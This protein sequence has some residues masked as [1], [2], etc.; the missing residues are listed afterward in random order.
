MISRGN[1]PSAN[2]ATPNSSAKSTN[3]KGKDH[4]EPVCDLCAG[5]FG[6]SE[7]KLQCEG[8]CG[9]YMHRYSAGLTRNHFRELST[10]SSPFVCLVCTQHLHKAT[11]NGL[12]EVVDKL[13]AE[14]VEVRELLA[15]KSALDTECAC[16]CKEAISNIQG[17]MQQ[18]QSVVD[19]Q[20]SSYAEI[21]K[22]VDNSKQQQQSSRMKHRSGHN[23]KQDSAGLPHP[24]KRSGKIKVEGSRKVWGTMRSTTAPAIINAIR[25]VS[26]VDVSK[27]IIRR[28]YKTSPTKRQTKWWFVIRGE[29]NLLTIL[30]EQWHSIAL[31][32]NCKLEPQLRFDDSSSEST[33][34]SPTS[35]KKP[36]DVTSSPESAQPKTMIQDSSELPNEFVSSHSPT[37]SIGNH[38]FLESK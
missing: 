19:S 7:E 11:V 26:V 29:E 30:K 10:N 12:H 22:R 32:T 24:L 2:L 5:T 3:K 38:H 13:K 28:K 37:S 21:V 31:Q 25:F 4:A 23:T 20:T 27:L 35:S 36:E 6:T 1:K 15:T 8:T 33:V 34:N 18:L 17:D 14:L 16:T 9:N